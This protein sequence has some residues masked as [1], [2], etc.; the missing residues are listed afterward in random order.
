M[1]DPRLGNKT[2]SAITVGVSIIV[3]SLIFN[4]YW[5]YVVKRYA[6]LCRIKE[7]KEKDKVHNEAR[8]RHTYIKLDE[9]KCEIKHEDIKEMTGHAIVPPLST[10]IKEMTGHVMVPPLSTASTQIQKSVNAP[11][12]MMSTIKEF[13]TLLEN[14]SNVEIE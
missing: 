6:S 10:D 7:G 5:I 2:K 13:S 4:G 11:R 1:F 9:I 12:R 14:D 8:L 3:I